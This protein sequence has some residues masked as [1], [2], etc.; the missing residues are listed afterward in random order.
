[1]SELQQRRKA[2]SGGGFRWIYPGILQQDQLSP[3]PVRSKERSP[4]AA[5]DHLA[6]FLLGQLQAVEPLAR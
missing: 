1:V 2:N 3:I 5:A 6:K 4:V